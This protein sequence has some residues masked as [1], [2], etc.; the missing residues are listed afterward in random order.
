MS[1][2]NC[3]FI[4]ALLFIIVCAYYDYNVE[5]ISL[6]RVYYRVHAVHLRLYIL[7]IGISQGCNYHKS[8]QFTYL[9]LMTNRD[10]SMKHGWEGI[11]WGISFSHHTLTA[12]S[13]MY[14]NDS[15]EAYCGVIFCLE[16]IKKYPNVSNNTN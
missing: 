16:T 2:L 14:Y 11:N 8:I 3:Y 5:L 1:V 9:F 7:F 12:Y 4:V 6:K 13:L 15:Q 10:G